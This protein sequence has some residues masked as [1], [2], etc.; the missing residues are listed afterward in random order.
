[1]RVLV[2]GAAGFIGQPTVRALIAGGH[3]VWALDDFSVGSRELLEENEGVRVVEA[4]IRDARATAEAVAQAA[5]EGVI[6]LAAIHF[7]PLCVA[8]PANALAVNVS[9]TQHLLDALAGTPASRLVFASTGDV[10][11]SA[12]EAHREDHTVAP[13]NV[14]GASKLMGEQLL[15]F[16]AGRGESLVTVAARLFNA[17]GPGETNP[18]V[19]PDIL[20]NMHSS[21][22]LRL[23]N[24]TPQRDYTY[25][26]DIASALAGL[27]VTA[28]ENTTVNVGAGERTSVADLVTLMAELTGRPLRI[29][30]DPAKVRASDRPVLQADNRRLLEMLPD[31]R[32]RDTREGLRET[33]RA[34]GLLPRSANGDSG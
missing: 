23:G 7:I 16:H 25:V 28:S 29:E 31:I 32:F 3:E 2:T 9:G 26:D 27:L 5:P 11:E 1:M 6:H 12:S 30:T 24:T 21:D 22:V 4:D 8:E 10:Y 18:H 20:G 13:N 17:F 14:Y 15:R 33:L 34:E 19:L